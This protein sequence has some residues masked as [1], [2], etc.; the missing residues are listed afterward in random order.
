MPKKMTV[1]KM[2]KKVWKVFSEY[3]RRRD[4]DW[5]GYGTCITCPKH[6][7]W[8]EGDAGHY[9]SRSKK[10][11][12]Y[13][14]RNVNLQCKGCNITGEP[15]LYRKALIQ[16]YG[17]EVVDELESRIHEIKQFKVAE[18][19]LMLEEYTLKL[20]QLENENND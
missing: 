6:L 14:E 12:L 18:L 15:Q 7:H 5:K 10:A 3:I 2:H 8:K 17:E 11:I 20:N 16:K 1:G 19:Q 9:I 13:D 4:C